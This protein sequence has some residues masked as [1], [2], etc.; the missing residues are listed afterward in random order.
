[1]IKV[2]YL[3]VSGRASTLNPKFVTQRQQY[4][5]LVFKDKVIHIPWARIIYV[6]QENDQSIDQEG[7]S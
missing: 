5:T 2:T 7:Q 6:E 4:A 3:N 1:M